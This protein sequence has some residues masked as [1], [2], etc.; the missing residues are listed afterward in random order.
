M[1]KQYGFIVKADSYDFN[2]DSTALNTSG[3]STRVVGVS[4]D[5]EAILIAK[6]MIES[7]IQVIELCG[8]F[9]LESAEHIISSLDSDVP[10]G[11]VTFSDEES[12]KLEQVLSSSS[13][14]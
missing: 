12:V 4:S 14:A 1:I 8:G 6:R 13:G 7:G 10:I 11:Y 5:E 3:F 2:R 9:G